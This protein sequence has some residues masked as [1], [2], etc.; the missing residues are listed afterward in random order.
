[1]MKGDITSDMRLMPGDAIFVP[2]CGPMVTVSGNVKRPAIYEMTD[3]RTL[4]IAL[5]LG[6]GLRPRAYNQRIQIERAYENK[7]QVVLDISYED[8]KQKKPIPV[9]DGDVIKVFS[10]LPSPVNAVY[11]YGNVLRPGEYAYEPGLRILDILPDIQSLDIDTYFNYALVKRYRFEDSKSELIPFDL[12][13]LLFSRDISQNLAL[14]P[15]DEVYI[16]NKQMFEDRRYA[17]ITGEV[18]NPGAYP[19]EDM[20]V[21]DLVFKAGNLT[22]D[23]YM[24]LGHLYRTNLKTKE[25]TMEVF[26]LARAM[27]GDP[28]HNFLLKDLDHVIIHSTWE[29][30]DRYIVSVAGKVNKP[31]DYPYAVNMTVRDLIL[32]GGNVMESA[33]LEKAEL[34]RFDIVEGKK[35]ETSL[36]TFDVR[37]AMA[38]DP[39]NN[40]KLKPFDVVNIK[41]IPDWKEVRTAAITGEVLFPGTYQLRKEERLSSLI[42]RAGGYTQEAYLRGAF[43]TRESV[44]AIQR[45]RLQEMIKQM[46]IE[47]AQYSSGEAQAALS[48]EDVA[49]QA[50]FL[51]A[52]KNLITKLREAEPSGRV[53]IS[54]LPTSVMKDASLDM[55]LENGDKLD[56]PKSPG[57]VNVLGAVYNPSALIFENKKPELSY[58]LLKTGGPTEQAEKDKMYLVRADGTVLAKAQSSRFA[59]GWSD[60]EKRW[61]FGQDFGDTALYPGDTVL[62]PQKVIKPHFMKDVKDITTIL[63]Q[64]AVGAG[65]VI[66]AF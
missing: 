33:Y 21:R 55:V 28:R 35:V 51:A 42:E 38:G 52:Q 30:V 23:A 14:K 47:V 39:A 2:Q 61:E 65:V 59:M 24:D 53:V 7:V 32:V 4:Q 37:K 1:L 34:M 18:R 19:I 43:F 49:A 40:I 50:Q 45:R 20:K 56:V 10:I 15:R 46:E 48:Q 64:I 29:Y 8:L 22:R 27:E 13:R 44:K 62:V 31:G 54:L 17:V 26:N 63:Y 5:E 16:F 25:V 66:A 6:G 3:G 36:V 57:T 9:Q 60:E 11:L 58:Y 41:E 12:G